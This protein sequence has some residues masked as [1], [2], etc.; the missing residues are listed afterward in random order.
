MIHNGDCIE[1]MATFDAESIDAIVTDPPYGLGFM[2]K[3]WDHGVPGVPF[4][5][6]MLRVAKP[7]AHLLA[8]GGTR[9]MH[10]ITTA[11]EDAGW[12][13][14]D[15]LVWAYASGFPKSLDVSKAIDK[16]D[17]RFGW[18]S[19]NAG[20][21]GGDGG[22]SASR[23]GVKRMPN[24]PPVELDSDEAKKW[25]GWGTALKPAWEPIVLARKPL[26][27]TV[28]GNVTEYGTGALNIDGC[29][30]GTDTERG[31]R[32]NGKAPGGTLA[33]DSGEK[34]EP[35]TVPAGRWPANVI[36]GDA[37]F[38]PGVEGVV[39]GGSVSGT[40]T[41]WD[42][43]GNRATTTASNA[44]R[45]SSIGA[46]DLWDGSATEGVETPP[47]DSET[48][49]GISKTDTGCSD[50]TTAAD[51]ATSGS[52]AESGKTLTGLSR[53]DTS[54]TTGTTTGST[55]GSTTS[56]SSADPS[57]HAT[58]SGTPGDTPTTPRAPT[59]SGSIG[60]DGPHVSPSRQGEASADRRY[61][62]R[63]GTNFA[64]LPG[65]RREVDGAGYSR[66]FLIPKA[67]RTDR[68]PVLG[69]LTGLPESVI[70][71]AGQNTPEGRIGRGVNPEVPSR[72]NVHPTVKPTDL[73][74]HLVRLVTPPGGVVLDPFLGSGTT[75]LA[76]EMEGF[77]W[78]GIEREAEYVAIAEA[79]LNGTQR[80]LGLD[81][82]APT[83]RK[84]E[85][86]A[87][88]YR[89]DSENVGYHGLSSRKAG[90]VVGYPSENKPR[91]PPKSVAETMDAF[92]EMAG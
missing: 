12:E 18:E 68:E 15:T 77:E 78:V 92:R 55:T 7:G 22:G 42:V 1:V 82:G 63:G 37:I 11:I 9:T 76:A 80:G 16:K 13:I 71:I 66:F 30:I 5:A 8:F 19:P 54:S 88:T 4:W 75:A 52:T 84:T 33:F 14:R 23:P 57:T 3:A 40:I 39:V 91:Q 86:H 43:G 51:T 85:S 38:E 50:G 58:T 47:A 29:R 21:Y 59:I 73:M 27:G 26:R 89:T 70:D 49:S 48:P 69:G 45:G 67:A 34:A 56:N 74:R 32:Y 87:A 36:L 53:A 17:G 44:A 90:T 31:D 25:Q 24:V 61:T 81:V 2:G 20:K 83:P 79:R 60:S 10:R 46:P 65:E 6:E 41:P 62:E 28:A 64:P 72:R 35:W